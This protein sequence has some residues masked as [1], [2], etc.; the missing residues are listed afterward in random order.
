MLIVLTEVVIGY[1]F[2]EQDTGNGAP[3]LSVDPS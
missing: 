3:T 1:I 2:K